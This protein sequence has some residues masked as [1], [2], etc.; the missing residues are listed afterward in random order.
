MEETCGSF[1]NAPAA[2]EERLRAIAGQAPGT[3]KSNRRGASPSHTASRC[4]RA[5]A[6]SARSSFKQVPQIETPPGAT[7]SSP[8]AHDFGVRPRYSAYVTVIAQ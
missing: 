7:S 1:A 6:C 2:I 4:A 8:R 5:G 3:G